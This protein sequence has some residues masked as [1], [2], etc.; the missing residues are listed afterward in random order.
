MSVFINF[1][2]RMVRRT[3]PFVSILVWAA[4]AQ[5]QTQQQTDQLV[6][7]SFE[8]PL[9]LA[10]GSIKADSTNS[11]YLS[12]ADACTIATVDWGWESCEGMD[13]LTYFLVPG[14]DAI[15]F[16]TPNSEGHVT[17]DDWQSADKDDVIK[18][19]ETD[20]AAGLAAQG[21][22]L[23][24]PVMFKRWLV[25]PTL[26][27]EK[28]VLYYA[29]EAMWGGEPNINIKASVFDRKGY[30][31]FTIVTQS[32]MPTE[33]EIRA[34]VH[35][36]IAHYQSE[37]GQDYASFVPG[38]AVSATGALGVLAA[39]VGVKFGKA[40]LGG[41]IA[42]ALAFLKKGGIILLAIPFIWLKN[43]VFGKRKPAAGTD[44]GRSTA[45]DEDDQPGS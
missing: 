17:M 15:L 11:F 5:A 27:T 28:K 23:G 26:D 21:E 41:I 37:P 42:V 44:D 2:R 34:M 35:A 24:V 30:V 20:L 9:S 18:G 45:H 32:N 38:D 4:A 3:V 7:L 10:R 8:G 14:A 43:R 40:A 33:A 16:E 13:A 22:K 19:I 29:T 6:P 25:Y 12:K 39:L 36:T 31:A 1:A